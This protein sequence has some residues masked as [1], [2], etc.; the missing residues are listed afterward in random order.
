M[1]SAKL[2]ETGVHFTCPVQQADC[3]AHGQTEMET[4]NWL[5][6]KENYHKLKT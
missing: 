5:A 6:S 1:P 4:P 2:G 3:E